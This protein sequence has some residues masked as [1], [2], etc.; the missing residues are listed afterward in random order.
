VINENDERRQGTTWDNSG[1]FMTSGTKRAGNALRSINLEILL[2]TAVVD[3][4][5][6]C[7][8][9]RSLVVAE[10]GKRRSVLPESLGQGWEFT[11]GS[12]G[13]GLGSER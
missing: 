3:R 2:G 11:G 5:E 10:W 1:H 6:V 9:L 4:F 13:G 12:C 8:F 7:K